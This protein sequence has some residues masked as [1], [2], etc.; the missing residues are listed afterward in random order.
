MPNADTKAV[1]QQAR[2]AKLSSVCTELQ[3]SVQVSFRSGM[4]TITDELARRLAEHPNTEL[5]LGCVDTQI[6]MEQQPDAH[7]NANGQVCGISIGL[8]VAVAVDC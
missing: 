5:V 2:R 3:K 1:D 8:A 7:A 4:A 6:S